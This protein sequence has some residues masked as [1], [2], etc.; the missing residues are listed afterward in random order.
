MGLAHLVH[1]GRC[2]V[3]RLRDL[4]VDG[5][6][7]ALPLAA[8]GLLLRKV[9]TLLVQLLTPVSHLLP[10]GRWFGVA[11]LELAAIAVLLL[12]LVALGALARTA[13]GR[14]IAGT[15]ERVVLSKMPGYMIMKSMA[16][17]LSTTES[18]P[19][20]RP[21]LVS[22][23]DN[24][25]LGFI[26]EGSATADVLTVFVPGAP[27]PASGNVMLVPSTRVRA[28]DVPTGSAMRSMKQRGLGL[29][30]ITRPT[31]PNSPA[32]LGERRE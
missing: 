5:L 20:L 15:L 11:A 9:I 2:E 24:T 28:L 18:D 4:L 12:A 29:Q 13:T 6:L 32:R 10:Q 14:G 25:V 21:A 19:G 26:V 31:L 17:D 1:A 8:A 27:S 30:Q 3:S 22:F 16:S 7:L 23:D